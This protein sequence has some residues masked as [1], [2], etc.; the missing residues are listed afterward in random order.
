MVDVG[1]KE[2]TAPAGCR[3]RSSLHA[4]GNAAVDHQSSKSPKGDVFEVARLAGQS[5]PAKEDFP[6]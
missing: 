4:A 6:N 5:W 2:I 1:A 3:R